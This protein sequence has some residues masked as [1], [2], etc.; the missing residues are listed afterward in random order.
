MKRF[1]EL[2]LKNVEVQ[3]G[4]V[5]EKPTNADRIRAMRDEELAK[6]LTIGEGGF[7]CSTCEGLPDCRCCEQNCEKQCLNW[8]RQPAEEGE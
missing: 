6:M 4:V 5:P 7:D 3:M 1:I 8:L 2:R